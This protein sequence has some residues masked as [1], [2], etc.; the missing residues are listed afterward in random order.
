MYPLY[1]DCTVEIGFA[2]M[3]LLWSLAILLAMI[4]Y[5]TNAMEMLVDDEDMT[6]LNYG[7]AVL[8]VSIA[9]WLFISSWRVLLILHGICP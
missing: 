4:Y 5:A 8:I 2:A 6:F 7:L 9:G 3:V 1:T